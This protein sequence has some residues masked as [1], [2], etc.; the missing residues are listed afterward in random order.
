MDI[1]TLMQYAFTDNN[2]MLQLQATL[3]SVLILSV[4]G[5]H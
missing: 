2:K 5:A 4:E 3:V 1:E